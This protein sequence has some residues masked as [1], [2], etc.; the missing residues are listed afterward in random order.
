[1]TRIPSRG[2][3][4]W[5][6]VD[7]IEALARRVAA[8][9]ARFV[10]LL[11]TH[12]YDMPYALDLLVAKKASDHLIKAGFEDFCHEADAKETAFKMRLKG[13]PKT[14]DVFSALCSG[15][16]KS[17]V[18]F[19]LVGDNLIATQECLE[20]K[21]IH[22]QRKSLF[23][24]ELWVAG[25]E[26]HPVFGQTSPLMRVNFLIGMSRATSLA[27]IAKLITT[28]NPYNRDSVEKCARTGG[29]K[30]V[31]QKLVIEELMGMWQSILHYRV[32]G[33]MDSNAAENILNKAIGRRAIINFGIGHGLGEGRDACLPVQLMTKAHTRGEDYSTEIVVMIDAKN[34]PGLF[35]YLNRQEAFLDMPVVY[36]LERR[37]EWGIVDWHRDAPKIYGASVLK[38]PQG[39]TPAG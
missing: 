8:S 29:S 26:K 5:Q 38:A 11:E 37:Q 10:L 22:F 21:R 2:H 23:V 33:K 36:D 25:N 28:P 16:V 7:T 13:T 39:P 6:G 15:R 32:H 1:M 35:D 18:R 4:E 34:A 12:N 19:H 30:E 3:P 31:L 9:P 24:E 17:N 20:E 14:D 27:D